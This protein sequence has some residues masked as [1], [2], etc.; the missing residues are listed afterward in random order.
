M[1][2]TTKDEF[3]K[4]LEQ[5]NTDFNVLGEFKDWKTKL[6][7]A[8]KTCNYTGDRL[9]RTI[10]N[11]GKCPICDGK[12]RT[13]TLEQVQELID[14]N[15]KI[16]SGYKNVTSRV[17]CKCEIDGCEWDTA[18]YNLING[19]HCPQCRSEKLSQNMRYTKEEV[20]KLIAE[21]NNTV[22]CIGRYITTRRN[23]LFKCLKCGREFE[24]TP[25]NVIQGSGCPHCAK[26]KGEIAIKACL[27]ENN[28]DYQPQKK[29][30]GLLGVGGR[31]LSYDF[32][33]PDQKLLI[34]FQGR[35][36]YE[37][38]QFCSR[39]GLTAEEQ[40]AKQQEHDKRKREYAINNGYEL[41]EISY[42]QMNDI[43][44]IIKGVIGGMTNG[45]NGYNCASV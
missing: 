12:R 4:R 9:P 24:T 40:F 27:E 31:N 33:L 25:H 42:K 10:L 3:L 35:G 7:V 15:I 43:P 14:S 6:P 23:A 39:E 41:L 13:R 26:S 30:D 37:P 34:E 32:Y 8:C 2:K 5:S 16:I 22:V 18:V 19:S 21:K 1:G 36:H 29:F 38:I 17:H 44:E 11:S 20:D 45:K 28:I